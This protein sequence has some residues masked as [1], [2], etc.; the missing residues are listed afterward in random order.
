MTKQSRKQVL[1]ILGEAMANALITLVVTMLG[2][3]PLVLAICVFIAVFCVG[4]GLR[5]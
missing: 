2:S 4:Y 1:L 5:K 3:Q